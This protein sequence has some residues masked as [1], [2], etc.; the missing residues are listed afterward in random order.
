MAFLEAVIDRFIAFFTRDVAAVNVVTQ[1]MPFWFVASGTTGGDH[2]H[3][4]HK[5]ENDSWR[6]RHGFACY[7]ERSRSVEDNVMS[8]GAV[9][10]LHGIGLLG[11]AEIALVQATPDAGN[12]RSS[13]FA[14]VGAI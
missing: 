9:A 14:F 8:S 13:R 12:A 2:R 4:Q 10:I 7:G 1:I 3:K 5:G 11:V 6:S